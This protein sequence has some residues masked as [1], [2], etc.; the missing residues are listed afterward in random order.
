VVFKVGFENRHLSFAGRSGLTPE[1][2]NPPGAGIFED[3]EGAPLAAASG[4][5]SRMSATTP[6]M[7]VKNTTQ[8]GADQGQRQDLGVIP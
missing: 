2:A 6:M 3:D 8:T 5:D 4:L 1:Q 7:V